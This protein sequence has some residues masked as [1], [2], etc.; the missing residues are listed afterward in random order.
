MI[1]APKSFRRFF[2]GSLEIMKSEEMVRIRHEMERAEQARS[3]GNEGM[4]RVCARRAV[5]WAVWLRYKDHF[6]PGDSRTAFVLLE[7]FRD[8]SGAPEQM[9]EA[10]SRLTA[11]ITEDHELPHEQDPLQDARLLL[12]ALI[13][14]EFG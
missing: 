8:R 9:R 10:A 6:G 2:F 1:Q 11:R 12:A 3:A 14:Q 4:A 5:G 13:P 7:W